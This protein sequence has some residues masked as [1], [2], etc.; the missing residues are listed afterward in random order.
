MV[1]TEMF[2]ISHYNASSD[3]MTVVGYEKALPSG[4]IIQMKPD[5]FEQSLAERIEELKEDALKK[6]EMN[7]GLDKEDTKA[8]HTDTAMEHKLD[9]SREETK[10]SD[11]E[12]AAKEY[13]E[14]LNKLDMEFEKKLSQ[15]VI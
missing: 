7:H 3:R 4:N 15:L 12:S 13:E 1:K 11:V 6:I 14:G 10:I 9:K 2:R 8:Y 5:K